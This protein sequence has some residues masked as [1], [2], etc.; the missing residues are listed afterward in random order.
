MA[1]CGSS[2]LFFGYVELYA[3]FVAAVTTFCCVGLVVAAGKMSRWWLLPATLLVASLHILGVTLIPAALYLLLRNTAITQRLLRWPFRVRFYGTLAL[4]IA[5]LSVFAYAYAESYF[6]RFAFVPL[7]DGRFV[8]E[9][10]TM[11]SVKHLLDVS[12]ELLLLVPG[13]PLLAVLLWTARGSSKTPDPGQRFLLTAA[14]AGLGALFIFDPKLGM[15]RDWDLFA[16]VGIPIA[17]AVFRKAIDSYYRLPAA[18]L[19]AVLGVVLSLLALGPRVAALTRDDLS[20]ARMHDYSALDRVK[21]QMGRQ[22]L[23]RYYV[24]RD[25]EDDVKREYNRFLRD[26]PEAELV[27]RG[28][29]YTRAGQYDS[30]KIV[31]QQALTYDPTSRAAYSDL[32]I[33]YQQTGEL[34]SAIGYFEIADGL[35]PD[36]P[37]NLCNLGMTY[38]LAGDLQQA[39]RT[40]YRAIDADSTIRFPYIWLAHTSLAEGNQAR[41]AWC[42][43]R[44]AQDKQTE[45]PVF[46]SLA[47]SALRSGNGTA[48]RRTFSLGI[49]AGMPRDVVDSLVSDHPELAAG[50]PQGSAPSD[51][52]TQRQP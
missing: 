46:K 20:L 6:F 15:P 39:T 33:V 41:Y 21:N 30:A 3:P 18:R 17:L 35:M 14:A 26:Y 51:L 36:A 28:V 1:G 42:L 52:P 9:G 16:F 44:L 31:L 8:V 49:Q 48:A 45:W 2:L 24:D 23:I 32:G 27:R 22:R 37:K 34:D 47:M 29:A 7:V 4:T 38:F 10:Y 50:N 19:A 40:L 5:A 43:E 11:F 25:L 12:N 13:L